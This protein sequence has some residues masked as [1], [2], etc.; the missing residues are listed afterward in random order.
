M[1]A[2]VQAQAP[3]GEDVEALVDERQQDLSEEERDARDQQRVDE[4][5]VP[6]GRH[7]GGIAQACG[8]SGHDGDRVERAGKRGEDGAAETLPAQRALGGGRSVAV[9]HEA[10][11][12]QRRDDLV[13]VDVLAVGVAVPRRGLGRGAAVAEPAY[14]RRSVGREVGVAVDVAAPDDDLVAVLEDRQ[15]VQGQGRG[16]VGAGGGEGT[17]SPA[18]RRQRAPRDGMRGLVPDAAAAAVAGGGGETNAAGLADL[19]GLH[20]R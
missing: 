18:A 7:E 19:H 14:E 13:D 9:A 1:Q 11:L 4:A 16:H 15:R 5:D 20:F 12:A 8:D 10:Q 6:D 3:A 2:R 17:R